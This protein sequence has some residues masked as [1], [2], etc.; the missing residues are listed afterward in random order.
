MK[1]DTVEVWFKKRPLPKE[2]LKEF[3]IG[4]YIFTSLVTLRGE[5]YHVELI[6]NG[7]A[8]SSIG[9]VGCR[10]IDSRCLNRNDFYVQTVRYV[11]IDLMF[12]RIKETDGCKYDHK[13]ILLSQFLPLNMHSSKRWYCGERV[14]YL[15]G[16]SGTNWYGVNNILP[17]LRDREKLI[18]NILA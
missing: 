9:G 14:M 17:L 8:H 18:Q 15:L 4:A 6:Y 5:Y 11:D 7:V 12:E 13:G 10:S 16:Y 3:K 1:L 2:Y